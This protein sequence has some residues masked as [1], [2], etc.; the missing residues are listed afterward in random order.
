SMASELYLYAMVYN[1]SYGTPTYQAQYVDLEDLV[2]N[3][4]TVLG[5]T[6]TVV[7]NTT[8]TWEYNNSLLPSAMTKS[9]EPSSFAGLLK[10]TTY[11]YDD[12]SSDLDPSTPNSQPTKKLFRV[13]EQGYTDEDFN[14][15]PELITRATSYSYYGT[16][17]PYGKVGQL[18]T[19]DGPLA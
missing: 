5:D 16:G 10:T 9:T 17:D 4:G 3:S 15:T 8:R 12:P 2:V 13:T 7:P 18:K 6:Y 14:G 1:T 19:V 11:D